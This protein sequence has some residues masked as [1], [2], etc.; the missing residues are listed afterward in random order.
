MTSF[1]LD[2]NNNIDYQNNIFTID[3]VEAVAQDIK[4]RLMMFRTEYPFDATIGLDYYDLASQNNRTV[5]EN[6]I[7]SRVLEDKR[8]KSVKTISVNFQN[9]NMNIR[10][11]CVLKTGEVISV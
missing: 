3:G 8:I 4:T 11:E 5:I 9:K 7:I 10:L 6:A 2:A 1:K